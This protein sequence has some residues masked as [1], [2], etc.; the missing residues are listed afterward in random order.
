MTEKMY[1]IKLCDI[2]IS[3]P[4]T[5]E[6]KSYIDF[7]IDRSNYILPFNLKIKKIMKWRGKK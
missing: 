5:E 3:V 4:I 2:M 1:R 7:V 6:K